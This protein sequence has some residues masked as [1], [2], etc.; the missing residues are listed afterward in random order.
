MVDLFISH[1]SLTTDSLKFKRIKKKDAFIKYI[2]YA[3]D[4]WLI[5]KDN[6]NIRTNNNN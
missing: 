3:H 6:S 1:I 4:F 5:Y 2:I